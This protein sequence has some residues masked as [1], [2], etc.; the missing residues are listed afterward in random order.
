MSAIEHRGTH[1]GAATGSVVA[2]AAPSVLPAA[3]RRILP[4]AIC[5]ALATAALALAVLLALGCPPPKGEAMPKRPPAKP[6]AAGGAAIAEFA[7]DGGWHPSGFLLRPRDMVRFELQGDAAD[8]SNDVVW[9]TIGA[10][11]SFSA[12]SRQ[13]IRVERMGEVMFR[14]DLTRMAGY[15]PKTIQVKTLNLGAL[16]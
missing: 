7:A 16:R 1:A 10:S 11:V 14:A 2:A 15:E 8:L 5:R 4:S 13:P 3:A 12:V 6:I 9:A